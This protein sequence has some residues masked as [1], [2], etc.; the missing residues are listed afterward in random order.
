MRYLMFVKADERSEA[1]EMPSEKEL[2]D[3][4]AYNEKLVKAGVLLD[5]N[6]LA[7]SSD[8]A[9]VVFDDTNTP[10]VIDGPFTE[11]K[12]LVAGYWLLEVSSRDE[13]VEWARRAPLG[14]GGQIEIRRVFTDEDFGDALTPEVKEAEARMREATQHRREPSH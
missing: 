3:M 2:A 12:E 5:G 1:G 14:P 9:R 8:G 7:P 13:A 6:G 11:T 10:T 4:T